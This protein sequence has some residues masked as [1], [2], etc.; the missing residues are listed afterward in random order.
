MN[1]EKAKK[2]EEILRAAERNKIKQ[3]LRYQMDDEQR[4]QSQILLQL[5][6]SEFLITN[7]MREEFYEE[8]TIEK[9]ETELRDYIDNGDLP[10]REDG[11]DMEVDYGDYGDR[12]VR[13][14]DDYTSIQI[15]DDD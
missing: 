11:I 14:Y 8:Y 4:L 5:G 7:K 1:E 13:D 9:E 2:E 10:Q 12:T 3:I 15:I 6:L